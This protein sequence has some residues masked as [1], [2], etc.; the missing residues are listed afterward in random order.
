MLLASFVVLPFLSMH[1]SEFGI[2]KSAHLPTKLSFPQWLGGF[3]RFFVDFGVSNPLFLTFFFFFGILSLTLCDR[4]I[5]N[6]AVFV[7]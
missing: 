6:K 2:S 4:K 3:M 1:P 7:I 5:K